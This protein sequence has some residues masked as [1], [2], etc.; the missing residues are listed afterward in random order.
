MV[1]RRT[2]ISRTAAGA[3]VAGFPAIINARAA[4]PVAVVTPLGFV[5]DFFDTMNAFSGGHYARFGL[6][7]KV[8]GANNGVQMT[9]LVAS[10]QA[11]FGRGGTPDLFRMAAARQTVPV[12]IASIDQGCVFRVFSPKAKPVREP[13]EFKGKTVGLITLASATG[14]YLDVMLAA[15]GLKPDDV[16]RQATGGTPG[17]VEILKQ[18]RVDCFISS[19]GVAVALDRAGEKVEVWNPERYLPLPGQCYLAMPTTLAA[20]PDLTVRFLKAIK[21]SLD[22]MFAEPL[23]PLI[24]RAASDF[25]IPG[26]ADID[27]AVAMVRESLT[28]KTLTGARRELMVNLPARWQGGAAALRAAGIV[29]IPDPSV[30]YTNKFIDQ[31]LAG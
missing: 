6:D 22:E 19:L 3:A 28:T 11:Q 27:L 13:K 18:G 24:R 25:D 5:L 16:E 17:A 9:Q 14:V 4:E 23:A 2:F 31:A 26:T 20:Q 15:A 12:S 8:I 21:A 10:G 7:A 1:T 29:D 30:L